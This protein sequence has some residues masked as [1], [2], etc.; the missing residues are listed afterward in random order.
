MALCHPTVLNFSAFTGPDPDAA[1][2]LALI[3]AA[4]DGGVPGLVG[5][6]TQVLDAFETR[7][8][9]KSKER[10]WD[11]WIRQLQGAMMKLD[12]EAFVVVAGQAPL[13][14]YAVLGAF[15]THPARKVT[16]VNPR[17]SSV[18]FV[19]DILRQDLDATLEDGVMEVI[20][21]GDDGS[22]SKQ[23]A[24]LYVGTNPRNEFTERDFANVTA[25]LPDA[26]ASAAAT[27]VA[28]N[29]KQEPLRIDSEN[30]PLLYGSIKQTMRRN[31]LQ[32]ATTL[33][34]SCS[35]MDAVAYLAAAEA[36]RVRNG[37][38]DVY[39]AERLIS[40]DYHLMSLR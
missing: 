37:F 21:Y 6:K 18:L 28:V 1:G 32:E 30:L 17:F 24:V 39:F 20:T 13:V 19:S 34:L 9:Y 11:V 36:V 33:V 8:D 23:V 35:S 10:P 5:A 22:S 2:L 3:D 16:F 15:L 40:G 27:A 25:K 26:C 7:T 29:C 4:S 12:G 14:L 38:E 31:E